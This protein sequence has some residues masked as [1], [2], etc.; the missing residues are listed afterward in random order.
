MKKSAELR[1]E[2]SSFQLNENHSPLL[3]YRLSIPKVLSQYFFF[4]LLPLKLLP[5]I[6]YIKK[7]NGLLSHQHL[8]KKCPNGKINTHTDDIV[9]RCNKRTGSNSRVNLN[10]IQQ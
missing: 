2:G 5:L 9:Q 6:Y 8:I 10:S 4:C 7:P 3:L 1:K